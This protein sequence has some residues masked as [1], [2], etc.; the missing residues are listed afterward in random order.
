MSTQ[1][2][3]A[4]PKT[5]KGSRVDIQRQEL[6]KI[7][8]KEGNITSERL[9]QL[10]S[11]KSHPLYQDFEWD[12]KVAGLKYRLE[13]ASNIILAQ[14]TIIES[15]VQADGTVK[16][17]LKKIPEIQRAQARWLISTGRKKGYISR[18][19][20][21]NKAEVRQHMIDGRINDLRL[22]L[23]ET[24]DLEPHSSEIKKLR[25]VIAKNLP[26]DN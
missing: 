26:K 17:V 7:L 10:A 5:R 3:Y 21:V 1:I 24:L 6:K 4:E 18:P 23:R 19:K 2:N 8:Q 22:W 20:A 16:G 14:A 11:K 15:I 13:Q 9:L 12:D 25:T